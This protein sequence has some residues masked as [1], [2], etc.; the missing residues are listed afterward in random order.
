MHIFTLE[1]FKYI[2]SKEFSFEDIMNLF[3]DATFQINVLKTLCDELL[4]DERKIFMINEKIKKVNIPFIIK[5]II[6]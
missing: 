4:N 1:V 3:T 5:I 2:T 6:K